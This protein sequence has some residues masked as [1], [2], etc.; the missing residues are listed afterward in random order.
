M[1][2]LSGVSHWELLHLALCPLDIWGHI[3]TFWPYEMLQAPFV[4]SCPHPRISHFSEDPWFLLV[5]RM[6]LDTP[7][8]VL[9]ALAVTRVS[10]LLALSRDKTGTLCVNISS[11]CIYTPVDDF[12]I[13]PSVFIAS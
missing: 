12:H 1:F 5:R 3:L 8:W 11:L 7:I 4:S 2:Q 13:S 6:G 10:L 9:R